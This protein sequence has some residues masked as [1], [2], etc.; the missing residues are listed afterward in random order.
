MVQGCSGHGPS[1]HLAGK[2]LGLAH[3]GTKW[4]AEEFGLR[5]WFPP[6]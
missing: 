5:I 4:R 3:Y 6:F 1:G 2:L